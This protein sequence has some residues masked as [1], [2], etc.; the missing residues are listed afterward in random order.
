MGTI[1]GQ[2]HHSVSG[3]LPHGVMIDVNYLSQVLRIHCRTEKGENAG[4][5]IMI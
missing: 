2:H 5:M 3:A 4:V 1:F